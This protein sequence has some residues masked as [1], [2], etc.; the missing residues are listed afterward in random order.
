V[1]TNEL[2]REMLLD[3]LDRLVERAETLSADYGEVVLDALRL[4]KEEPLP[5]EE[6][7]ALFREIVTILLT[8]RS[9]SVSPEEIAGAI[10]VAVNELV[11]QRRV[12][13]ES[14][15]FETSA[16]A[17]GVLVQ[18]GLKFHA[19]N[20]L[21][22]RPVVP[23]ATFNGQTLFLTEGYVDVTTLPLW[24]DNHRVQLH[25]QE[26]REINHKDP[27]PEQLLL[28]MHGV[29]PLPG[30]DDKDPFKLAPLAESIA[31][32]GVERPPIVTWEGEPK[33]G[34][35]RIAAS[36]LVL[37]DQARSPEEKERARWI[38]VWQ[39]TEGTTQDQFEAI[40]VALNFEPEHKE[41][42]PEYVKARLVV[43]RYR[44]LKEDL[45]GGWNDSKALQ[46]RKQVAEQFAIQH[47]E[48]KRYL[49]MVLWA[50]DFEEYHTM[51]RGFDEA[52]VRY[53]ANDIFQWF[54]EV[55]AGRGTDKLIAKIVQDEAL[56]ATVYDLMYDVLQSGAQVRSLH[57]VVVDESALELLKRAHDEPNPENGSKLVDWAIAEANKN[58]PTKRVGFEQF[59]RT[60][61]DRLGGATIDQWQELD[62][63]L[64]KELQRV[65]RGAQ[66]AIEG[67]LG[68]GSSGEAQSAE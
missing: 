42:W 50:D 29:L 38:R 47:S 49:E 28:L 13:S 1:S 59:L 58:S 43:E 60:V 9:D 16:S 11:S 26:F 3:G 24:M 33:D 53:K 27:T 45:R 51:E 10:E 48:V 67:V 20:G 6:A 66:G 63:E 25:V 56:R 32:K 61:V 31:R 39:A 15:A 37:Q 44:S 22:P 17:D 41:Q 4:A 30:L 19:K 55:Q 23:V 14:P 65:W 7:V 21:K 35:R 36:L 62:H 52:A 12:L 57:K 8:S 54:Y 40:V 46:L 64:L 34:N 5:E 68:E 2:T 18:G